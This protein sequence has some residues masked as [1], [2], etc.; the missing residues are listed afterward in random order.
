[1]GLVGSHMPSS[2]WPCFPT[3]ASLDHLRILI[4]GCHVQ[5]RVNPLS[6]LKLLGCSQISMASLMR[7]SMYLAVVPNTEV[8]LKLIQ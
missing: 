5:L 6:P 7:W 3:G 1:M 2:A 4:T 8:P